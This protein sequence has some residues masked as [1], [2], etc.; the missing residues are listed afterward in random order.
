MRCLEE[1]VA[2]IIV[3]VTEAI[4]FSHKGKL[5]RKQLAAALKEMHDTYN[6]EVYHIYRD[7]N[8]KEDY[9]SWQATGNL[10]AVFDFEKGKTYNTLEDYVNGKAI[11]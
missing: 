1:D 10:S 7:N 5:T 2:V 8:L 11:M 9:L 4:A 6:Y 3:F